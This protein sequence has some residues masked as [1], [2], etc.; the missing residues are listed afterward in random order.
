MADQLELLVQSNVKCVLVRGPEGCGKTSLLRELADSHGRK[1]GKNLL[2]LHLGEQVD[3]KV[4]GGFNR[5]LD[6]AWYSG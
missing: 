2:Y 1:L 6:K 4:K 3:G 5:G